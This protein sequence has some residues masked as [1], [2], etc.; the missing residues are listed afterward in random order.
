MTGGIATQEATSQTHD[1]RDRS[2]SPP[3]MQDVTITLIYCIEGEEVNGENALPNV[4][5]GFSL[6][7]PRALIDH[8]VNL[9]ARNRI[10]DIWLDPVQPDVGSLPRR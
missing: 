5:V 9:I 4:S 3:R 7:V 8:K 2:R 10:A 6:G 1:C